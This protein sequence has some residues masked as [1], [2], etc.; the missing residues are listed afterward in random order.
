MRQLHL[1]EYFKKYWSKYTKLRAE[2]IKMGNENSRVTAKPSAS[3][4]I[5]QNPE[6]EN[7]FITSETSS[8]L[9]NAEPVPVNYS[10]YLVPSEPTK[11]G[12]V[13]NLNVTTL[14]EGQRAFTTSQSNL[15]GDDDE[16]TDLVSLLFSN[17][18]SPRTEGA[19]GDDIVSQYTPWSTGDEAKVDGLQLQHHEEN[20]DKTF[21]AKDN[22]LPSENNEFSPIDNVVAPEKNDADKVESRKSLSVRFFA[23]R[24]INSGKVIGEGGFGR[25][26]KG[27]NIL[28]SHS[29]IYR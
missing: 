3:I 6:A 26:L 1:W 16:S 11:T 17:G 13:E 8:S 27:E 20:E 21:L 7:Y 4:V 9:N 28:V 24:E 12:D 22:A 10:E 18:A 23:P 14:Q 25:V 29:F 5:P 19:T 15:E 2:V